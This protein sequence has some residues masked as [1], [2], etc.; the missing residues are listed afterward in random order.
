MVVAVAD[1][2]IVAVVAISTAAADVTVAFVC[3]G[4]V[5][6]VVAASSLILLLLML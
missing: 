2:E 3:D 4:V 5:V 6:A 1:V